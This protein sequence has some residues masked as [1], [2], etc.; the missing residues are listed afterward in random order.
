VIAAGSGPHGHP[1][2]AAGARR[3]TGQRRGA[4]LIGQTAL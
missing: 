1:P 4:G 2:D 3:A